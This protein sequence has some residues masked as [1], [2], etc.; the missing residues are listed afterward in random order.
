MS[1]LA[2]AGQP[3]RGDLLVGA[4]AAE[5]VASALRGPEENRCEK[6][7]LERVKNVHCCE[8]RTGTNKK[9]GTE[10]I[11]QKMPFAP[12]GSWSGG[13]DR[14]QQ[15]EIERHVPP[16][17]RQRHDAD[18]GVSREDVSRKGC[19]RGGGATVPS[20]DARRGDEDVHGRYAAQH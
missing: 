10:F 8:R 5:A 7:R 1:A 12:C 9:M 6:G 2:A 16:H 15:T 19:Q 14:Q 11:L 17:D 18:R 3:D 13:E 20:R 4:D